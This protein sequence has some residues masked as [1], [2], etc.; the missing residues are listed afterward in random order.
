MNAWKDNLPLKKFEYERESSGIHSII[1]KPPKQTT[2]SRK[3]FSISS[4]KSNI[5]FSRYFQCFQNKKG[6]LDYFI[7]VYFEIF[8]VFYLYGK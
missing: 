5:Y 8:V 7:E 6:E 3:I 1:I 4:L 2:G